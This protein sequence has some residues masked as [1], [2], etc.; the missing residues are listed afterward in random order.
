MLLL[1]YRYFFFDWLFLDVRQGSTLERAAAWRTNCDHRRYLATYLRRWAVIFG[2][3]Y[4]MGLLFERG[5]DA[6][7][8]AVCFYT[9]SMIAA[10]FIFVIVLSWFS[11]ENPTQQ[12]PR[13]P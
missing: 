5:L 11:L 1:L 2:G 9:S 7:R 8:V 10:S 13:R 3:G 4:G 12:A 6:V